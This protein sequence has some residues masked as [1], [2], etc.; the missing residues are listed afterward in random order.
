MM[1]YALA[2]VPCVKSLP[3]AP[4]QP[5]HRTIYPSTKYNINYKHYILY[6]YYTLYSSNTHTYTRIYIYH[7]ARWRRRPWLVTGFDGEK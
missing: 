2:P 3:S 7:T 6:Y 1:A 4:H 5:S